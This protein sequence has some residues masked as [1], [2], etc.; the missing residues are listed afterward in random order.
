MKT[1]GKGERIEVVTH[2]GGGHLLEPPYKP[3]SEASFHR[4]IGVDFLWGG[5]MVEHSY[6]QEHMWQ[7]CIQFFR[8]NLF[9]GSSNSKAKL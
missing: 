2:P 1:A 8:E 5:R 9:E 3:F 7:Q 6:A 4:L